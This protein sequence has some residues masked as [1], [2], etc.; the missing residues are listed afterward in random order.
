[1]RFFIPLLFLASTAFGQ[2]DLPALYTVTDV[3]ADDVLN[4]REE[5]TAEAPIVDVLYPGQTG[6]EV[7]ASDGNWGLVNV[8]EGS[9]WASLRY[10]TREEGSTDIPAVLQPYSCFGTEP[11]WS[12]SITPDQEVYFNQAF[13]NTTTALGPPEFHTPLGHIPFTGAM[14]AKTDSKSLTAIVELERCNDGMSDREY[15]MSVRVLFSDQTG[16]EMLVG[17]C[18]LSLP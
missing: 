8:G 10:L 15:G 4:V 12:F 1:M 2:T 16:S 3:A 11:F 7:I 18:S 17:C 13:E 14:T 9:G 6:I 5:P